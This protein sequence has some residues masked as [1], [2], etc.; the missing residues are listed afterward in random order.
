[1]ETLITKLLEGLSVG[2]ILMLLVMALIV[3][4]LSDIKGHMATF[5]EW[6]DGHEKL[7]QERHDSL[8]T[9]IEAV[10]NK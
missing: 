4:Y 7:D 2:Q 9:M 8:K 10:V 5:K 1:M 6:R 3:K